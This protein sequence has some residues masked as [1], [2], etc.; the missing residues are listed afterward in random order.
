MIS[1]KTLSGLSTMKGRLNVN[2]LTEFKEPV[3]FNSFNQTTL[4]SPN[5]LTN[6][7]VQKKIKI[8]LNVSIFQNQN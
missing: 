5:R 6:H 8:P 2:Y 4:I 7:L 1:L 3:N